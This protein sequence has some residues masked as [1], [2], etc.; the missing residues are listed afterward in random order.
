MS[1]TT[2]DIKKQKSTWI[3]DFNGKLIK[4]TL[5]SIRKSQKASSRHWSAQVCNHQIKRNC[6]DEKRYK[7]GERTLSIEE[8]KTAITHSKGYYSSHIC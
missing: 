4:I 7:T 5:Q 6:N 2:L 8:Q 3:N 1:E